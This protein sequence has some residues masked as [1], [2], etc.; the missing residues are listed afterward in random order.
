VISGERV[1]RDVGVEHARV[2]DAGDPH[3]FRC[4]DDIGVVDDVL[5]RLAT[6]HQRKPGHSGQRRA[7]CV[8]L[9]VVRL[10]RLYAAR[11]EVG[12]CG[13]GAHDGD[14]VGRQHT[15]SQKLLNREA[16][17]MA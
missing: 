1:G 10:A 2:Q 4:V 16:P 17:E 13:S 5:A 8:R 3:R 9:G 15:A 14:D 7:Q 6:R 12:N 11:D